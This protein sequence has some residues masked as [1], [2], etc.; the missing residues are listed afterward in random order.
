MQLDQ[1]G[2]R[3]LDSLIST[4]AT[5]CRSQPSLSVLLP[6]TKSRS[7]SSPCFSRYIGLIFG[8]ICIRAYK[9]QILIHIPAHP[10]KLA[11]RSNDAEGEVNASGSSTDEDIAA[12]NAE[13]A[14]VSK[15]YRWLRT[16]HIV[17]MCISLTFCI[18]A[19][20]S[21]PFRAANRRYEVPAPK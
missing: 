7:T 15:T 21:F 8:Q 1:S 18:G 9:F 17:F 19:G 13:V 10:R 6:S 5:P 20:V 3:G 16:A 14:K 4:C 2:T 12:Y 11:D